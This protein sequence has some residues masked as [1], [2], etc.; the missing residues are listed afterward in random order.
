MKIDDTLTDADKSMAVTFVTKFHN[1]DPRLAIGGVKLF[2]IA[3]S[4]K[5]SLNIQLVKNSETDEINIEIAKTD[6]SKPKTFTITKSLY[7]K[8]SDDSE[9]FC[10]PLIFIMTVGKLYARNNVYP[11]YLSQG[12]H[13][14]LITSYFDVLVVTVRC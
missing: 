9:K 11:A 3:T 6:G 7:C 4:S 2:E 1:F 13:H 5:T 14:F 12:S 8:N 10:D